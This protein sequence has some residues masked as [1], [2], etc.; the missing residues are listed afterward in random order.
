M[1]GTTIFYFIFRCP[2]NFSYTKS[3]QNH[4]VEKAYYAERRWWLSHVL[5][6]TGKAWFTLSVSNFVQRTRTS[7]REHELR[8]EN[9]K[10]VQR[11]RI[12]SREHEI[13][14]EKTKF[15]QRKRNSSREDELRPEKTNF[16][17]RTRTSS[18][19]DELRPENTNF[20]QRTR[21]SP[22]EHEFR[23][24]NT[25]FVPSSNLVRMTFFCFT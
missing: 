6:K 7:S 8:P 16:V 18:R 17:Q 20:V 19:E 23:P 5:V 1:P 12:S 10:F 13:R 22:R 25:N 4:K 15:V 21:N 24:E 11:T 3:E 14:P 2:I 9:T